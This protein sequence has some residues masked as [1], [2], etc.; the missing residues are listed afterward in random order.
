MDVELAETGAY[1]I[2]PTNSRQTVQFGQPTQM[3]I[4]TSE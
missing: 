1:P 4:I 2:T 3:L